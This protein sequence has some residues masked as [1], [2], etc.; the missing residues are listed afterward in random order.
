MQHFK[1]RFAVC[2][3]FLVLLNALGLAQDLTLFKSRAP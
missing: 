1:G 2:L 3:I